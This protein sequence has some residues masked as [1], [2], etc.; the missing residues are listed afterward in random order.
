MGGSGDIYGH[1]KSLKEL[2]YDYFNP[3]GRL[4]LQIQ[5][6]CRVVIP[7][8]VL[9]SL[10]DDTPLT[11]DT[12]QVGCEQNCINRFTPIN[13]QRVWEMQLFMNLGSVVV[14]TL[15]QL[16]Q[17]GAFRKHQEKIANNEKASFDFKFKQSVRYKKDGSKKDNIVVSRI[18]EGII[19]K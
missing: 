2:F 13:H 12:N 6:L 7:G 16:I 8:M 15:F 1:L 3:I 10:F 18:T 11:C 17:R 9:D 19:K 4:H 5:F 14:F